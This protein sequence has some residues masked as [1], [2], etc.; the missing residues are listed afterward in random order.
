MDAEGV[1]TIMESGIGISNGIGWSPDDRVMYYSDSGGAGVV[2]AYDF[3]AATGA[4]SNRR[5]FL[6]PT[7]GKGV[8]DGL[9]VDSEGGV[10]CAFWDGWRV[11]RFAP[12]GRS[13]LTIPMPV[14][15]PTSCMFGGAD[16]TTLYVTSAGDGFDPAQQPLA[17]DVFRIETGVRG[18]PEPVFKRGARFSA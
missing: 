5:V 11:E 2:W 3:D 13:L 4:I 12:D 18:L 16:L 10:W 14:Q 6:P 7:E 8:A 9:T 1:V 15:R 17:G